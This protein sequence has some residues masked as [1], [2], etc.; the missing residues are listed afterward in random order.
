MFNFPYLGDRQLGCPPAF[1]VTRWWQPQPMR[2]T[3]VR[4]PGEPETAFCDRAQQLAHVWL[5]TGLMGP[6]LHSCLV[7]I[8]CLYTVPRNA[9]ADDDAWAG[10]QL[11]MQI[12]SD[13]QTS[14]TL[15]RDAMRLLREL[16]Q[17]CAA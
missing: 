17:P 4:A 6:Q 5:S 11:C 13:R 10:R 9:E 1:V 15:R 14:E 12:I 7:T 8:E 3:L 16:G 2:R